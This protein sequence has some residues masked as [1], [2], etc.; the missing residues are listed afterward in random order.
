MKN[1]EKVVLT[2]LI[3]FFVSIITLGFISFGI[4]KTDRF[5][6]RYIIENSYRIET[7]Y[8]WDSTSTFLSLTYL[9]SYW[10][11]FQITRTG[12]FSYKVIVWGNRDSFLWIFFLDEDFSGDVK[13]DEYKGKNAKLNKEI[14]KLFDKN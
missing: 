4:Q 11:D 2:I 7:K 12:E 6:K 1:I 3:S 10:E 8:N 5:Y 9:G 13:Y 14:L